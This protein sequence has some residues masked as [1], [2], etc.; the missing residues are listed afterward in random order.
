MR[1]RQSFIYKLNLITFRID[2]Y[3][4]IEDINYSIK[5]IGDSLNLNLHIE[6]LIV[7]DLF[8]NEIGISVL[9]EGFSIKNSEGSTGTI[10][11]THK[12]AVS[13][14]GVKGTDGTPGSTGADGKRTATGMVYYQVSA[15][16]APATPSATS[17]TFST[18]TFAGLTSNWDKGAPTFAA[19]NSNKYWYSTYTVVE[20]TAG[21]GKSNV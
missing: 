6:S 10:T 20:T 18:A 8:N 7:D 13:L 4:R 9:H 12:V 21:G 15:G 1:L 14:E 19:G 17:F 5:K 16:S 11:K 2:I 3:E